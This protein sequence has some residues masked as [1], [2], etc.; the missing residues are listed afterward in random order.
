MAIKVR[1]KLEISSGCAILSQR[2]VRGFNDQLLTF[3]IAGLG[4]RDG[5]TATLGASGTGAA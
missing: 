2:S 5:V 1:I 4:A 3:V